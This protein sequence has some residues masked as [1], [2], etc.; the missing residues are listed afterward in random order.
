MI[1][2][3][4]MSQLVVIERKRR[5]VLWVSNEGR[6]PERFNNEL[7][8][9]GEV[10]AELYAALAGHRM[11]Q[12]PSQVSLIRARAARAYLASRAT[13]GDAAKLANEVVRQ[14]GPYI[15]PWL[16]MYLFKAGQ[17][18]LDMPIYNQVFWLTTG[19][20]DLIMDKHTG[21]EGWD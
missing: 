19:E 9:F 15:R 1:K 20:A 21:I 12:P 3:K 16:G 5:R 17:P 10:A 18:V 13:E 7:I 14:W 6:V 4:R 8:I 2:N 11:D